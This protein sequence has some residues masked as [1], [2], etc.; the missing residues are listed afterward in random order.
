MAR[1]YTYLSVNLGAPFLK[2]ADLNLTNVEWQR[3]R[4]GAGTFRGTVKLPPPVSPDARIQCQLLREATDNGTTCIY[5]LRDNVPMGAWI[6]WGQNYNSDNQTIDING[7]ELTSYFRRRIIEDV[8]GDLD[9]RVSYEGQPMYDA[10]AD[11]VS[12][13]NDIGLS[14]DVA[15][16]G[17]ELPETVPATDTAA[18]VAGT[19]WKGTDVKLVADAIDELA[20]MEDGFDYRVDLVRIPGVGFERRFVLRESLA[21]ETGI[22]AK[23]GST[24][25]KFGV[26]RR[27]DVRSNDVIVVGGSDGDKRPYGRVTEELFTPR[28]QTVVQSSDE[29]DGDRLD[30]AAQAAMDAS[31]TGEVLSFDVIEDGV[32]AVIGA[33]YPGDRARIVIPPHRD[34]WFCNGL[35]ATVPTLG[36]TVN[37]P[38]SGGRETL[39][40][41][42]DEADLDG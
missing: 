28:L 36:F 3:L 15:S 7:S 30:A 13:V 37:V 23:Y 39:S 31:R 40:L 14:L 41:Q 4:N 32:D 11:M 12:K 27:G 26:Q 34:P 21:E 18:E 20:A 29:A 2:I 22:V 10:V 1:R 16:G 6:V 42:I 38:D 25:S 35:D 17:P 33:L 19:G 8:T 24:L 9:V 5:V